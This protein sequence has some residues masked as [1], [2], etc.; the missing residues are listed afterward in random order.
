[1]RFTDFLRTAVLLFAGA[2]TA[3]AAVAIAGARADDDVTLLYIALGWW[4]AAALAG[5]WIGWRAAPTAGIERLMATARSTPALPEVGP[6]RTILNRLWAL[7]LFTVIAGALAFLIPQVPAIG[8]GYALLVALAWRRQAAAV[9]A[10]EERDG[11]SFYVEH[12]SPLGPTR[13]LRTTGLRK[14]DEGSSP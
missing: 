8:A 1:V 7:A 3:L 9:T 5:I 2:A 4:T 12:T 10:V 13:L 14:L 6:G 11:V